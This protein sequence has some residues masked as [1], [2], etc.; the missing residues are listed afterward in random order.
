MVII[1]PFASG[2]PLISYIISCNDID[3]TDEPVAPVD[4]KIHGT[5]GSPPLPAL[6]VF[7]YSL[8]STSVVGDELD[9]ATRSNCKKY[10]LEELPITC[11]F[12]INGILDEPDVESQ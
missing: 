5:T 1:L 7:K 2:F 3:K 10:L 11:K 12:L 4:F 9:A 8:T 6:F